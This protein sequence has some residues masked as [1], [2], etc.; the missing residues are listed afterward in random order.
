MSGSQL[1]P[2]AL[3]GDTYSGLARYNEDGT[4]KEVPR[5]SLPFQVIET[6][7]ESRATREGKRRGVQGGLFDVY[8]GKEGDRAQR[9]PAL[10][11]RAR[12]HDVT[13]CHRHRPPASAGLVLGVLQSANRGR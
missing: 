13:P 6:V 7:N 11:Q 1:K 4:L 12:L 8:E 3:P 9:D 10:T 2:P 5:V